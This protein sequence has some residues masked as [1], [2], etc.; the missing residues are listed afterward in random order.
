MTHYSQGY[1][2]GMC[3]ICLRNP[4]R[5]ELDHC[6]T[7]DRDRGWLCRHCNARL[8]GIDGYGRK[9]TSSIHW[10]HPDPIGPYLVWRENCPAC[11][12]ITRTITYKRNS[13]SRTALFPP[14]AL[15]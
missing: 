2:Y 5:L 1:R 7:H 15:L 11:G 9:V 4:Q 3:G 14:G 13:S 8:S 10:S 12:P 6:H